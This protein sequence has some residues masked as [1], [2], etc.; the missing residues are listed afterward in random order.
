MTPT[1]LRK[2]GYQETECSCGQTKYTFERNATVIDFMLKGNVSQHRCFK[3][4]SWKNRI[5]QVHPGI[6]L[7][8]HR[9]HLHLGPATNPGG[10]HHPGIVW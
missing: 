5:N 4:Q 1:Q 3:F 2:V 10:K 6:P 9:Q 8:S 7:L